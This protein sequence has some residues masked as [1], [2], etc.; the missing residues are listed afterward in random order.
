M[1][2]PFRKWVITYLQNF[3]SFGALMKIVV[4]CY[5]VNSGLLRIYSSLLIIFSS[6]RFLSVMWLKLSKLSFFIVNSRNFTCHSLMLNISMFCFHFLL[7]LHFQYMLFLPSF[8]RYTFLFPLFP[9]SYLRLSNIHCHGWLILH[10]SSATST[11][12]YLNNSLQRRDF[13]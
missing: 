4:I 11:I 5:I 2:F 9:S 3:L 12:H 1:W 7:C 8:C 6:S 10:N 13:R